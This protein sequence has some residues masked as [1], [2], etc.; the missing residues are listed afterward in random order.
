MKNVLRAT[1]ALLALSVSSAAFAADDTYGRITIGSSLDDND[2]TGFVFAYDLETDLNLGGLDFSADRVKLNDGFGNAGSLMVHISGA[3]LFDLK[4][5][6]FDVRLAGGIDASHTEVNGH[7]VAYLFGPQVV[8][9]PFNSNGMD[10][11]MEVHGYARD[12]INEKGD[13]TQF[14]GSLD[15]SFEAIGNKFVVNGEVDYIN[16]EGEDNDYVRSKVFAGFDMVY[17][18]SGRKATGGHVDLGFGHDRNVIEDGQSVTWFG[19]QA[20]F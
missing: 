8:F 19:I 16:L 1:T 2:G 7:N 6:S 18:F 5:Q 10:V 14:G 12:G 4:D 15:A 17:L 9:S 13:S 20:G 11:T 3:K